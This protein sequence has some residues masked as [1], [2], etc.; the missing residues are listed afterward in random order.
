MFEWCSISE[1]TTSSPGF[2]NFR[3]HE[4][5]TRL[6]DSVVLR[7]KMISRGSPAP[8]KRATFVRACS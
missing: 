4:C 7:V 1:T 6:I 8:M 2:R 3:A 5:A